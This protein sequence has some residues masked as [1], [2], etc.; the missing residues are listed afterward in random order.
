MAG[1]MEIR[2]L[3]RMCQYKLRR[4]QS[5][6]IYTIKYHTQPETPYGTVTKTQGN[7]THKRDKRSDLSQQM[8]TRLQGTDNTVN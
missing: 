2:P 3:E 8:I 6:G 4:T 1:L 7:I 5:S